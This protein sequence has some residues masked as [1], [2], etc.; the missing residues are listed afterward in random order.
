MTDT[1]DKLIHRAYAAYMRSGACAPAPKASCVVEHDGLQYVA[2]RVNDALL[3]VYRVTT[4]GALK[5]LRRWPKAV[6][7]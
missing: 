7:Q 1:D 3:G 4:S 2:L 6:E 5:R